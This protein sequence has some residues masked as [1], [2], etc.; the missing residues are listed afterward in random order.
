MSRYREDY[1]LCQT[2]FWSVEIFSVSRSLKIVL[3]IDVS[4]EWLAYIAYTTL[5]SASAL[6]CDKYSQT[7]IAARAGN[8]PD[9]FGPARP[10]PWPRLTA[11]ISASAVPVCLTR[12]SSKITLHIVYEKI[13]Q[14]GFGDYSQL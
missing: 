2:W 12:A 3:K 11:V 14:S 9:Y 1:Q 8:G 6:Q 10:C 13:R 5:I 7:S 4:H